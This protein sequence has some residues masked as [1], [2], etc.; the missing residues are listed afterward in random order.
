MNMNITLTGKKGRSTITNDINVGDLTNEENLQE[1][2]LEFFDFLQTMGA[3][4]PDELLKL[5]EEYD[6]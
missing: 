2:I 1:V 3:E 6:A 4:L 5:L